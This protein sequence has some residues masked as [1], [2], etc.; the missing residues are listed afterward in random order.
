M[1]T[2]YGEMRELVAQYFAQSRLRARSNI[3]SKLDHPSA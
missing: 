2:V 3:R 1:Q